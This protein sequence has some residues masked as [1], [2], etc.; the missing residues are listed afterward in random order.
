MTLLN[1][2]SGQTSDVMSSVHS[3]NCFRMTHS[4]D[5]FE[6]WNEFLIHHFQIGVGFNVKATV[7]VHVDNF[8]R[9]DIHSCYPKLP[10]PRVRV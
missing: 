7:L 6:R 2:R 9:R 3:V 5:C 1:S 8:T 4:T 10:L